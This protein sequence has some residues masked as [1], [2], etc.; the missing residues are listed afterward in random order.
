MCYYDH[1]SM[2]RFKLGPWAP[3]GEGTAQEFA[4]Q[5]GGR[6]A[7]FSPTTPRTQTKRRPVASGI[8]S[9]IE[10]YISRRMNRE[11]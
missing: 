3:K 7:K 9:L 8:W 11:Q 6:M 10:R 1:A 4:G 2:M 5:A